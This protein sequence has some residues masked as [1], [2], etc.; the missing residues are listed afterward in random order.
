VAVAVVIAFIELLLFE[1]L[2]EFAVKDVCSPAC[3]ID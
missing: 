2:F 1:K 3:I